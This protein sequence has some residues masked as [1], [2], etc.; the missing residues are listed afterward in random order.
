MLAG[1]QEALFLSKGDE[2]RYIHL[3][4]ASRQGK[5][6]HHFLDDLRHSAPGLK[7][8]PHCR[9]DWI[10][11][12]LFTRCGLQYAVR[13]KPELVLVSYVH[14]AGNGS[15]A[16][17]LIELPFCMRAV[18]IYIMKKY[19][20]REISIK[21]LPPVRAF[22]ATVNRAVSRLHAH[23]SCALRSFDPD[24]P[25][26]R[27]SASQAG[28]NTDLTRHAVLMA[29]QHVA[30]L[31]DAKVGIRGKQLEYGNCL[32]NRQ[33]ALK[34]LFHVWIRVSCRGA[35]HQAIGL[36]GSRF[37]SL[38]RMLKKLLPVLRRNELPDQNVSLRRKFLLGLLG[39]LHHWNP[40]AVQKLF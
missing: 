16:F 21:R 5:I 12:N 7:M 8:S 19:L 14:R 24:R 9:F 29:C 33:Q 10:Q 23:R 3:R 15:Q 25:G 11:G 35:L 31:I 6:T 4:L 18:L 20:C 38:Q 32:D 40:R 36:H 13:M 2:L 26:R 27:S 22:N 17:A 28:S 39:H 34:K 1:L 37:G 30:A